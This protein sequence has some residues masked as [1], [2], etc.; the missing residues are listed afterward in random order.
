M[1]NRNGEK[2]FQKHGSFIYPAVIMAQ[3][4]NLGD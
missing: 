1:W 4:E 2:L 3:F